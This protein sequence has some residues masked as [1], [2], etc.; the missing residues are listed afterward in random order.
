MPLCSTTYAYVPL[1][2]G[3][4]MVIVTVMSS[5]SPSTLAALI[6]T[7]DVPAAVGVP[8]SHI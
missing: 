3:V 4:W 6:L 1:M 7:V 8:P 2:T 5:V